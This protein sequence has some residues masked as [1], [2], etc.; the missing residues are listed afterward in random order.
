ML[1]VVLAAA[2]LGVSHAFIPTAFKCG[3]S[4]NT[5]IISRHRRG[6]DLSMAA[7]DGEHAD[8]WNNSF[9]LFLHCVLFPHDLRA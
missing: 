6:L 2:V 9:R 5:N 1:R 8:H 4:I 3:S 7:A